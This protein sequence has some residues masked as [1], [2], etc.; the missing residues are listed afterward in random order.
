MGVGAL[1]WVSGG[2]LREGHEG[3]GGQARNILE[4]IMISGARQQVE[5]E[6]ALAPSAKKNALPLS[7]GHG[8]IFVWVVPPARIELAHMD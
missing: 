7:V 5:G 8:V 1:G 3:V 2:G 6:W 4:Y